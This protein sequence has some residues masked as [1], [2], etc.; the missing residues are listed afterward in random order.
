MKTSTIETMYN[1]SFIICTKN[2]LSFLKILFEQFIC[3]C[4]PD[5]E[6]IVID[7]SSTDGSK[8][9]LKE[10]YEQGKIHQFLSEP[11]KNQAHGWNKGFLLANGTIIKKLIDD[12]VHSLF[13]IRQCKNFMLKNP[14]VDICIS[15]CLVTDLATPQKIH[16]AGRLSYYEGW[17]NGETNCFTFSDVSMLIRRRSLSYLGL[18]DTQFNMMD[19]E[20][21]LRCSYLKAK[22][23]YYLGYNSLTVSTPGNVT[24]KTNAARLKMEG[25]I[26][27]HKYGYK[28]DRSDISFYSELKIAIGKAVQYKSVKGIAP[29]NNFQIPDVET[30][31]DIYNNLYK[32]LEDYNKAKD[33]PFDYYW[34]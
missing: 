19:W 8:E 7:G 27:K 30:L 34:N 5:E 1:L 15:N 2:R 6:I 14:S 23:A 12:D 25:K 10:L 21:S 9:F 24:S 29:I 17:K 20:Y 13:A 11:D 33:L 31:K 4:E 32:Y 28:G 18:Y 3:H 22:I 26:G 16:T